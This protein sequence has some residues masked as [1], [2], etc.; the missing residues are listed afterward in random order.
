MKV[1]I[2]ILG[3]FFVV[4]ACKAEGKELDQQRNKFEEIEKYISE[5]RRNIEEYYKNQKFELEQRS[6]S[7]VR[8]LKVADSAVFASLTEQAD[9]AKMVLHINNYG[10]AAPWYL[11]NRTEEMLKLKGA[12]GD[13]KCR[14]Q[15]GPE[16]FVIARS[17]IAE[18]E[19]RI[20]AKSEWEIIRLEKWKENALTVYLS[21]LKKRLEEQ[22]LKPETKETLGMVTGIIHSKER[23]SA[24]VDR[25]IV[26]EGDK[27]HGVTII[28]IRRDKVALE[29]NGI[30]WE[31]E[32]R[33]SP[34]AYWD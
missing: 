8:L 31:Q 30:K 29:K 32:V 16:Q 34:Q 25:I 19:N 11:M 7:E 2:L 23:P 1:L 12:R 22:L 13:E 10:Y 27:V 17:Q 4:V 14:I 33:Q 9:V 6:Q 20:L 3:C 5:Q 24:I 28:Q 18:I 15:K 21:E 26:H